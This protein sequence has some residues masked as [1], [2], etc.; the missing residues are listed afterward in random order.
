MAEAAHGRREVPEEEALRAH[1]YALLSRLLAAPPT[2]ETL[3]EL[4]TLEGDDS[5]MGRALA[6]LG[7]V[8]RG[9][10]PADVEREYNALFIGL[11]RGELLPYGSYYQTGFLHEKPLADIRADLERFGIARAPGN[12]EPEDHVATLCEVMFGLI[13]GG[14]GEVDDLESQRAFFDAHLRP[15][16]VKFFEDLEAAPSAAFYVPVA[17]IG[18]L[19][20]AIEAEAFAMADIGARPLN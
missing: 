13:A 9:S 3:A 8:A 19:F 15:W 2:A 10:A 12:P 17:A 6:T 4:A 5:E 1:F 7:A 11:V 14:F 20:M 18:R 16:A